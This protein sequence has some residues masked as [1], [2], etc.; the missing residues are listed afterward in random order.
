MPYITID[1]DVDYGHKHVTV[2]TRVVGSFAIQG[3]ELFIFLFPR[4]GNK[5]TRSI[6]LSYSTR[7]S[8]SKVS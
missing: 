3:N 6:E 7:S 8:F 1:G 4:F 2:N 5:A